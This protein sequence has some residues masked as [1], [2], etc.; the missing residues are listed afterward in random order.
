[1]S[2]RLRKLP[3]SLMASST[4]LIVL[5]VLLTDPFDLTMNNMALIVISGLLL[6]SFGIFAGL[7]WLENAA[8]EREAV[9]VDKAGRLGYLS[10]LSVLVIALV[11]QSFNHSVDAWL[12]LTIA[13]MILSKHLYIVIKK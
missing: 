9:L 7:F 8:D 13:V 5:G 12:V 11:A 3:L 4:A 6:A 2:R 1:M 10:G